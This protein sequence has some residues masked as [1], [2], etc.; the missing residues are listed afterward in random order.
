MEKT[1]DEQAL[2]QRKLLKERISGL[3]GRAPADMM[4]RFRT[5]QVFYGLTSLNQIRSFLEPKLEKEERKVLIIT[6]DFTEKFA[7]KVIEV[8]NPMGAESK[9]WS[10]VEPE[11]PLYTIE[12]AV[13]ICEGYKPTVFIAIG[14]GSVMDSAKAIMLKYENPKLDLRRFSPFMSLGLRK[15]VK[16][17]IAVPTTSGTGSEATGA[18]M[19][20]DMNRDPPKKIAVAHA[21]LLP[22]V[23]ILHTDFVKDM[24][25]FLTMAS[26]LDALAHALG[27]YVSSWGGPITDA[28][29]I[30]AIKEI[31]KYL[32]RAY[33]YGSKDIEARAKMQLATIMAG[34]GFA[35][36]R[37]G[38]DHGLGHSMGK[39]LMLHHGFCVGLF[40]P[41]T[42]GYT[43]KISE[44][45]KDL[46]PIFGVE[47]KGKEKKELLTDLLQ[48]IKNFIH[49]IDGAVCVKEIKNPTI[50]KE[51][52]IEK[53]DLLINYAETDA[54]DLLAPRYM[55]REIY[56]KI[57]EYAWDGR[58]IDF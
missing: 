28:L 22:D 45:W 40:L 13:K 23:A 50:T 47:S 4:A 58:D 12:E 29:N 14:G 36:S 35:N 41:Y 54:V 57:F 42:V 43:A 51:E 49:S 10:G 25:P 48:A 18:A 33:K 19:L 34:M 2:K 37:V 46:C 56:K 3:L 15:K 31:L 7:D 44:R 21:E 32:P 5:S 9:V 52:Y 38:L 6:D 27:T 30:G 20:T 26:G 24:P 1:E 17:L 16:Y 39:V 53:M 55:N 11:G 8:L